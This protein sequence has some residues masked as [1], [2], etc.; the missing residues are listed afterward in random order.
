M[1]TW[2]LPTDQTSDFAADK[3]RCMGGTPPSGSQKITEIHFR[4]RRTSADSSDWRLAVYQGGALT[5]PNGATLVWD[6]SVVTVT[7]TTEA[8]Y[9][10]VHSGGG[11]N[12]PN[13]TDPLWLAWKTDDSSARLSGKSGS[14]PSPMDFQSARGRF[15]SATG[16]TDDTVAWPATWPSGSTDSTIWYNVWVTYEAA[17]SG[18]AMLHYR[19]LR[20]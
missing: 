8:E 5:D 11:V 1:A 9:S 19:R 13:D 18:G 12:I 16:N 15:D 2:G 3:F 7:G 14:A 6:A 10:K 17:A 4:G 20:S